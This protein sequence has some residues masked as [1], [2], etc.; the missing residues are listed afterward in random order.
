MR[1]NR[2]KTSRIFFYTL[3]LLLSQSYAQ[4]NCSISEFLCRSARTGPRCIQK[5]LLCDGKKVIK[6][7]H[8]DSASTKWIYHHFDPMVAKYF[9]LTLFSRGALFSHSM[10]KVRNDVNE[11]K[12]PQD[13][14][15][16]SDEL[17]CPDTFF[18]CGPSADVNS[19]PSR[20]RCDGDNVRMIV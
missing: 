19:I 3:L 13:C 15:D 17:N 18:T 9:V 16:G 11:C 7:F 4:R 2:Y 12:S 14:A 10:K 8:H 1:Q 20:Y 6:T 5:T